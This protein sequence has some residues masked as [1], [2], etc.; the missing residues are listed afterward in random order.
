MEKI[1]LA[2]CQMN[3]I[4]SKEENL[5]KAN[6]MINDAVSEN[7]DFIVLPEMFNCP[8]SNEKFIEY[9]EEEKTSPTLLEI[10][11]LAC[12]NNVY[13][14]A[15]SIPEK[16]GNKLYNTSYLF[17][18]NG[19]II[20]KHRKMHLFDI[21]VKGKIT[22]MESDVLTAGSYCSDEER[23]QVKIAEVNN[24]TYTM[25]N[26]T[27]GT[28]GMPVSDDYLV[29]VWPTDLAINDPSGDIDYQNYKEQ[30]SFFHHFLS[31]IFLL[32]DSIKHG[33]LF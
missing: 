4:D 31:S 27:Y 17:N 29:N 9:A 6:S 26:Y 14:L 13:I 20:A 11:Q 30:D 12:R 21:D 8:Y 23:N 2:L 3:V 22:F 33:F 28:N 10:S 25:L 15:G 5:K 16:E 32:R 19:E 24:I 7:A 1:K 18:K